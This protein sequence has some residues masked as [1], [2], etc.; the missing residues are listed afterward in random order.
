LKGMS[1]RID[2]Y[3]LKKTTQLFFN[4][5][6]LIATSPRHNNFN[7]DNN[8]NNINMTDQFQRQNVVTNINSLGFDQGFNQNNNRNNKIEMEIDQF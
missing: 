3:T 8:N 1:E 7:N 4:A 5:L 6:K 2:S